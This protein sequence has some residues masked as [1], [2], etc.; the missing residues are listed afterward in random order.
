MAGGRLPRVTVAAG[1]AALITILGIGAP[2]CHARA[3]AAGDADATRAGPRAEP[4]K[5]L[6]LGYNLDFPGDWSEALPFLDL[7]R[8]A[9]PWAGAVAGR[10]LGAKL[11]A[12]GWPVDLGNEEAITSIVHTNGGDGFVGHVWVM[13]WTGEGD[14]G[15]GGARVIDKAPGRVRFLG[16]P[17]NVW[18]TVSSTDPRR[19]GNHVRDIT[20]VREDRVALHAQGKIFNPDFLALL[21]PYRSLRFMDWALTNSMTDSQGLR[22]S[23][24]SRPTQVGWLSQFI[25]PSRPELGVT[26]TGYPVEVQVELAKQLH[27]HPYFNMPTRAS[28]EYLRG[29]AEVVRDTLPPGLVATVE[30]SNEVWNWGFPQ[31]TYARLEGERLWP[32]EGTAWLQFMGMRASQMCTIWKKV[33]EGQHHRMRC[34]IAPQTGWVDVAN[35]SLDC[36]RWAKSGHAPCFRSADAV[37]ITGYFSGFLQRPENADTI[38]GW[39]AKGKEFALQQAFRQLR[40]GDVPG[41]KNG[42]T[43]VTPRDADS[44][45]NTIE[46]F[47]R[48]RTIA[49]QRGLE[50]I[51]YEGGT[52]FDHGNDPVIKEF[53]IEVGNDPR[54]EELYRDLFEGF[55]A[56]GGTIFHVWGGIGASSAWAN[57]RTL[58]DRA[59][60]KHRAA[61]AWAAR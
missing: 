29:F 52:H 33:F 56:A 38:K 17:E 59:H 20:V 30:Y 19:V 6:I 18:I 60:P 25:D 41:L 51:A 9:R 43:A 55:A 34:V 36:P 32:G 7:M 28:D 58:T 46:R 14:V 31:A 35:A 49:Q 37:A 21:A 47:Q 1:H 50:L 39:L 22:W 40:V 4:T 27:A 44:L 10:P 26:Q 13:R 15:V 42:D 16:G 11:D 48:Y 12:Q 3:D 45:R 8:D 57:A 53:L 24:R 54:M 61:V 23:E 2:C 5:P